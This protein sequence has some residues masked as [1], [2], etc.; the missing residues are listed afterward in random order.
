MLLGQVEEILLSKDKHGETSPCPSGEL[1][2]AVIEDRIRPNDC[3]FSQDVEH[4]LSIVS[5]NHKLHLS[6][7]DEVDACAFGPPRYDL[8][9]LLKVL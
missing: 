1:I 3:T 2:G 4:V 7:N 8:S 9:A 6:A 5:V